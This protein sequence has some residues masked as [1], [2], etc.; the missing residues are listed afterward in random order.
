MM[1]Q[2]PHSKVMEA[3]EKDP[4]LEVSLAGLI[5]QGVEQVTQIK[6]NGRLVFHH[7]FQPYV[8]PSE[9]A[10][11]GANAATIDWLCQLAQAI[12]EAESLTLGC[13]FSDHHWA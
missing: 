9:A 7:A 11:A 12:D 8:C 6:V 1:I 5:P 3:V 4:S 13:D 2:V 10:E